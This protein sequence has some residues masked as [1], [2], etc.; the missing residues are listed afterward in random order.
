M[1]RRLKLR[2]PY[3]VILPPTFL[4]REMATV[5]LNLNQIK[6]KE[7]GVKKW[8]R[9]DNIF[10]FLYVSGLLYQT[11]EGLVATIERRKYDIDI[12]SFYNH[13]N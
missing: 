11:P 12:Y 6:F 8:K 7:M 9:C 4:R 10:S 2:T 13:M 3:A 1:M 5:P